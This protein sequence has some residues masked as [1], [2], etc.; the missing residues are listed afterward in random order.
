MSVSVF[1]MRKDLR[2]RSYGYDCNAIDEQ[3]LMAREHPARMKR[4]S[5]SDWWTPVPCFPQNPM[6]EAGDFFTAGTIGLFGVSDRVFEDETARKLLQ[7]AGELLPLVVSEE[8]RT[9]FC[10]RITSKGLRHEVLD[11][12]RSVTENYFKLQLVFFPD[13]LRSGG[14]FNLPGE[15]DVFAVHDPSLP[16]D[17][18]FFQWYHLKGYTGLKFEQMWREDS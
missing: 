15:I 11:N 14:C 8:S 9:V 18:D 7:E 6:T 4:E 16:P 2:F 17:R 10:Y 12:E 13:R 3:S 1:R 5:I